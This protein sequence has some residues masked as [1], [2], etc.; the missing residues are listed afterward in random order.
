MQSFS[1]STASSSFSFGKAAEQSESKSES[2]DADKPNASKSLFSF[3]APKHDAADTASSVPKFSF[4]MAANQSEPKSEG[5]DASNSDAQKSAFSLGAPQHDASATK[6][7]VRTFSFGNVTDQKEAADTKAAVP[8][9]SFGPVSSAQPAQPSSALTFSFGAPTTE[10]GK[11][12]PKGSTEATK[13]TLPSFYF[14]KEKSGALSSGAPKAL[15]KPTEA[16]QVAPS[17]AGEIKVSTAAS[18]PAAPKPSTVDGSKE[19]SLPEASSREPSSTVPSASAV[20]STGAATSNKTKEDVSFASFSPHF[21]GSSKDSDKSKGDD[22]ATISTEGA[23]DAVCQTPSTPAKSRQDRDIGF[24]SGVLET[25]TPKQNNTRVCKTETKPA[26]PRGMQRGFYSTP[27]R[28]QPRDISE[29]V[30]DILA[31]RVFSDD[32]LLSEVSVE[33]VEKV[34]ALPVEM[35]IAVLERIDKIESRGE[36]FTWSDIQDAISTSQG[37]VKAL[38]F[39]DQSFTSYED[40][41]SCVSMLTA[42]QDRHANTEEDD[43]SLS[44]RGSFMNEDDAALEVVARDTDRSRSE[45]QQPMKSERKEGGKEP[46]E[47]ELLIQNLE[48]LN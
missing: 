44:A 11:S 1:T 45:K 43:L 21:M 3:G 31:E 33:A 14:G 7:A 35:M 12:Q 41:K 6:T 8:A 42:A 2:I 39:D 16:T 10:S 19:S 15:E 47:L 37:A 46:E 34:M 36:S 13:P 38:N 28:K 40:F 27:S 29:A 24:Q 4:G 25:I 26:R 22:E 30:A 17:G 18:A 9:F 32:N 48:F 20:I 5:K 23:T